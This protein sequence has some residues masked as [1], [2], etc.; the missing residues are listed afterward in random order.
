MQLSAKRPGWLMLASGRRLSRDAVFWILQ[1]SG[2]LSFGLMML[3]YELAWQS[4][5][6]A[7]VGDAAL[8]VSGVA[9]SSLYRLLYRR[10]RRD[11]VSPIV[12]IAVSVVLT[13]AGSPAW[14]LLQRPFLA[15]GFTPEMFL[16]YMFILLTWTLLYFGING[17]MSL[18]LER[19][20]ADR[21][22]ATA[23]SARLQALQAHLQPHFLFNTLNGISSLVAEGEN[24][25]A[26]AMIARLSDFLR[27]TLQTAGTTEILLSK[28]LIF[29]KQYLDI[30]KMR[31]GDRLKFTFD[32]SPDAMDALVPAL[33]LQPLVENAVRHGILPRA[34]GGSLKICARTAGEALHI[35]VDDDGP[36]MQKPTRPAT[37][38]GLSN[39][40]T[41]L[42][43]LYGSLA[44]FK[45]GRSEAGGVGVSIRIPLHPSLDSAPRIPRHAAEE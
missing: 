28:D 12:M 38:L 41:R 26:T 3:G 43:E 29:V 40:A 1:V 17:W 39:T 25:S 16:Y 34:R 8:V 44:E 32:V 33:L 30:Q 20:R 35:R 9:L 36:G 11:G 19:R 23:Q 37:G 10:L 5:G 4:A 31:F 27:L 15:G 14:Y 24:E 42:T 45:V 7:V 22:E 21:A 6:S 13:A 18:E 2:W